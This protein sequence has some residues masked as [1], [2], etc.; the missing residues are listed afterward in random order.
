MNGEIDYNCLG[1]NFFLESSSLI[2]QSVFWTMGTDEG[3]EGTFGMGEGKLLLPKDAKFEL[4]YTFIVV[5]NHFKLMKV[6]SW[7]TKR[8][9]GH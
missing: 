7:P 6:G 2:N 4:F 8:R 1:F 9:H 5:K 3:S